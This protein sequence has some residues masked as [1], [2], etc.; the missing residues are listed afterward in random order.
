MIWFWAI[1]TIILFYFFALLQSSFFIYFSLFGAIPN[2]VFILFFLLTFFCSEN[3]YYKTIFIAILAGLTIDIFYASQIGISIVLL[4]II[5]FLI[6]KTQ[7]SL[8]KTDDD[9][10]FIPFFALFLTSFLAYCLLFKICLYF[11]NPGY[12]IV[13]FSP[14]LLA[15]ILYSSFFAI[16]AFFIYKKLSRQKTSNKNF[17]IF[18]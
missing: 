16:L 13:V 10:P 6:T 17:A 11:I 14:K 9:Y 7:S 18:K 1:I 4:I 8:K 12:T 3:N 15:E 2:F 5:G